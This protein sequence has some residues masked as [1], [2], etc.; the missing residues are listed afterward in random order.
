MS[1]CQPDTVALNRKLWDTVMDLPL[2][3]C[4]PHRR[5]QETDSFAD[6][7]QRFLSGHLPLLYGDRFA[8]QLSLFLLSAE[9]DERPERQQLLASL[10]GAVTAADPRLRSRLLAIFSLAASELLSRQDRDLLLLCPACWHWLENETE[11]LSGSEAMFQQVVE[12]TEWLLFRGFWME[13]ERTIQALTTLQ[14]GDGQQGRALRILAARSLEKLAGKKI[15]EWLADSYFRE[16]AQQ[17]E[18]IAL[19][20]ALGPCAVGHI[21]DGIAAGRNRDE[22]LQL[23]RL[24]ASLGAPVVPAVRERLARM[25][26]WPVLRNILAVLAA[27]GDPDL[28]ADAFPYLGHKDERVQREVLNFT[29]KFVAEERQERLLEALPLVSE[30]LKIEVIRLLMQGTPLGSEVLAGLCHLVGRR[31]G[32]S[33]DTGPELLQTII[34]A[35]HSFPGRQTVDLLL[36]LR[37]ECAAGPESILFAIDEALKVVEPQWRHRRQKKSGEEER[38]CFGTDP[39]A[40]QRA[41]R[42]LQEIE[43]QVRSLLASSGSTAAGELVQQ[44]ARAAVQDEELLLAEMLR[45]RL[46]EVN[47][48]LLDEVIAL[49]QLIEEK[50]HGCCGFREMAI[51][52]DFH[53]EMSADEASALF[54]QLRPESYQTGETIVRVGETDASLYFLNTGEIGVNCLVAGK[55]VFLKRVQPGRIL[56]WEQFLASSVWTY[57]LRALSDV[58]VQVLAL[59]VYQDIAATFPG[60]ATALAGYCRS[61]AEIPELVKMA[62]EDRREFPRHRQNLPTRHILLDRYGRQSGRLFKGQMVDISRGGLAFSVRIANTDSARL[63]LGRKILTLFSVDGEELPECRGVVVGVK[64]QGQGADLFTLH[65]KMAT[66]LDEQIVKRM[67]LAR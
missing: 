5:P 55:E 56:G 61:H 9:P 22:R 39:A 53:K 44:A 45:D 18:I 15:V 23:I 46:L 13:A 19:L 1:W 58:Q 21:L 50:K 27:I 57:G 7:R 17:P 11:M 6:D 59:P 48:Q 36:L 35:L 26:P 28:Y 54:S 40:Q 41:Y 47:P 2:E 51:W 66:L 33:P 20:I 65:I 62:G 10:A 52:N 31:K 14:D 42:R 60:I 64:G 34:A 25:P 67:V 49:E 37:G 43:A 30:R 63:L 3:Y 29:R 4:L 8:R 24:A 16:E 12:I 32:F 38:V